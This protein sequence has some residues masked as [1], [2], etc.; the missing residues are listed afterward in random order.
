MAFVSA[1]HVAARALILKLVNLETGFYPE[2]MKVDHSFRRELT[3]V[4]VMRLACSGGVRQNR[5]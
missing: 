4:E 1:N 3:L 5:V 2:M